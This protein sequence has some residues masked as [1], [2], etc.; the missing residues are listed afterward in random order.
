MPVPRI[1]YGCKCTGHIL[2]REPLRGAWWQ[3]TAPIFEFLLHADDNNISERDLV[4]DEKGI[5]SN[6]T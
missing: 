1:M 5:L 3:Y 6:E 2:I 4:D